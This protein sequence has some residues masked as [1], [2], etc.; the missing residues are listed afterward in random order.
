M[1]KLSRTRPLHLT[2]ERSREMSTRSMPGFTA[3]ASL[4]KT[5]EQV[6]K[7]RPIGDEPTG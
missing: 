7:V 6:R 2:K 4:C 5:S 1:T 3:E